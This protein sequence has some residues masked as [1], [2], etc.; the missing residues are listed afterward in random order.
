MSW[1]LADRM[2][3][4]TVYG[5]SG[6]P[7]TK[8]GKLLVLNYTFMILIVSGSCMQARAVIIKAIRPSF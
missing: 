7:V 6:Q 3:L 5:T 2:H 4:M 1:H 8:W